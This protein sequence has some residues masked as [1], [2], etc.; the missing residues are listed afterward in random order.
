MLP[1]LQEKSHLVMDGAAGGA[2]VAVG[3]GMTVGTIQ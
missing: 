2:V 1:P 3:G